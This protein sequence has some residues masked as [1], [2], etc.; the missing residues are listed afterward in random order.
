M[1][2]REI[3]PVVTSHQSIKGNNSHKRINLVTK[4]KNQMIFK[5]FHKPYTC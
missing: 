2:L 4:T 5:N 1:N 3:L